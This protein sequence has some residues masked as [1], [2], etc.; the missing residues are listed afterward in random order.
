MSQQSCV[1]WRHSSRSA[2]SVSCWVIKPQ[3]NIHRTL[4]FN[5]SL[6]LCA[7]SCTHRCHEATRRWAINPCVLYPVESLIENQFPVAMAVSKLC[8]QLFVCVCVYSAPKASTTR[9]RVISENCVLKEKQ[10]LVKMNV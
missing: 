5:T 4:N 7:F 2:V 8:F 6:Y 10:S 9:A 3:S 1:D